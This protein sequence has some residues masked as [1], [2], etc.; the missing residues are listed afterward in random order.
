MNVLERNQL[1]DGD[2]VGTRTGQRIRETAGQMGETAARASEQ[3]GESLS[4]FEAQFND[5]RTSVLD[6]TKQYSR[7][8]NAY[9]N[10]NPWLAVGISAGSA[11]LIGWLIGRRRAD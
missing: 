9:V 3:L 2:R 5:A 4:N 7:T 11:F 8:A 10:R 1:P 6:K